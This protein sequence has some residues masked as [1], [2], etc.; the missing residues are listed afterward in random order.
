M[1]LTVFI[2]AQSSTSTTPDSDNCLGALI[3]YLKSV[4][5]STFLVSTSSVGPVKVQSFR[6]KLQLY[7]YVW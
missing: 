3:S 5:P 6:F 7:H 2:L 4:M 1:F